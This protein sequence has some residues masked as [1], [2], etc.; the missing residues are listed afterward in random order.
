MPADRDELDALAD[1]L[2]SRENP[3]FSKMQANRIWFHLMGRG[4]VD[5]VDDFRASNPPSHPELIEAL[6]RELAD[7]HFD[8]RHLIRVVMN[9]RTYQLASD[10][11]DTN[12]EDEINYSHNRLRRLSAEQLLD[13]QSLATGAALKLKDAPEGTTRISQMIEGRKHYKP[14]KSSEDKFLAAFGKPPRLVC[15]ES[16][17]SNETT[18][19]QAFQFLSG[20]LLNELLTRKENRLGN[21]VAGNQDE[22]AMITE[23]YWATLSRAPATTELSRLSPRLKSAKDKRA[24][25]EDIEWALLNSKEFVFRR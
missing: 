10:A 19:S 5:P 8:L 22:R 11:N 18:M 1:W 7:H 23:L 3:W 4:L 24:A 20:P 15:S 14:L 25:L 21:L 9:S 17:R 16:E 6:A 12:G 2:T 13:S